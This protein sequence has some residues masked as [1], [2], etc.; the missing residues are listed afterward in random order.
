MRRPQLHDH[1]IPPLQ[2]LVDLY[3]AVGWTRYTTDPE[4]LRTAVSRSLRV[5]SAWSDSRL[6]GLARVV[7]DGVTIIY[8]Q[9]ILVHPDFQRRGIGSSLLTEALRPFS[10][11]RQQ[12]LLTDDEPRQRAFYEAEGFTEIRDVPH[13]ALRAFIRLQ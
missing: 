8:L 7:G 4:R 5:V 12:V 10:D 1:E 9:D 2:Q 3:D 11:V 6:I 13:T